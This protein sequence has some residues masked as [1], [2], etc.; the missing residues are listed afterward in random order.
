MHECWRLCIE[1]LTGLEAVPDFVYNDKD[2]WLADTGE[3]LADHGYD[4]I[5]MV[6]V[7]QYAELDISGLVTPLSGG[8]PMIE[9][10]PI[11]GGTYHAVIIEAPG[12]VW[13][14]MEGYRFT[15]PFTK[16][17]GAY[18]VRKREA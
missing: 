4:L 17:Y 3:W 1:R 8:L 11:E 6:S 12:R 2:A 18:W 16:V 13:D 5:A 10:G 7:E 14:P 15:K 9:I